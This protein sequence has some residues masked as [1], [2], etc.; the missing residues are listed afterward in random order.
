MG[1]TALCPGTF[2]PVTNGHLDIIGRAATLYDDVIVSVLENPSKTPV[3][4]VDER[5]KLL[6]EAVAAHGNVRVG[7][8]RGLLVEYARE[9]GASAIL[10]GLRAVSDYEYEIQMA[11]MNQRLGGVET[12]FL[13]TSP[14]WS[15]LSSSLVKEVARLG[16]S[17]EGLV[18]EHVRQ[19]LAERLVSA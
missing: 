18:P 6:R 10:K 17:V 11:Q 13:S 2:D 4:T 8:F 19:A 1:L 3:F 14:K 16:G 5:V 7:S 12:L 9:Q 15:F